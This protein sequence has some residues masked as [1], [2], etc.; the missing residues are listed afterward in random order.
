MF[1][2]KLGLASAFRSFGAVMLIAGLR[3]MFAQ[4]AVADDNAGPVAIFIPINCPDCVQTLRAT[5]D[6]Q[7]ANGCICFFGGNCRK[8]P[9]SN[10]ACDCLT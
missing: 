7:H 3:I 6:C 5:R 10:V 8:V 4:P 9:G 1:R 2:M